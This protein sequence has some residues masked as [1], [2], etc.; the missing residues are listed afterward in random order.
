MFFKT[1]YILCFIMNRLNKQYFVFCACSEKEKIL[2]AN[3]YVS[4]HSD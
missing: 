2:M 4:N 1:F 3:K